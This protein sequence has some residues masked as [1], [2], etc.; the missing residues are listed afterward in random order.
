MKKLNLWYK[1][2]FIGVLQLSIS[3]AAFAQASN[4]PSS[5]VTID[6]IKMLE[7]LSN[8]YP[9]L[10]KLITAFCYILGF[11]LILRGVFYLKMYGELRTMMSTQTSAK[12]PL[13]LIFVGS[14][15]VFLPST[16]NIVS[17]SFFGSSSVLS[18]DQVTSTMNPLLLKAIVGLVQ[19]IGLISFIKGWMILVAHAQQPG[20]QATVGKALTHIIGGLCAY[21]VL[22]FTN[23]IWNTFYGKNLFG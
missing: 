6:A 2:L 15:F 23:V 1:Y 8:S 12:I 5:G 3:G 13:I 7:N 10:M 16:Y 18:Y 19:I 17:I 21:N 9:A 14:L 20:G 11:L 22:G 4:Q